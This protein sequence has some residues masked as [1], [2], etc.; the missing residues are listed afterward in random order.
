VRGETGDAVGDRQARLPTHGGPDPAR[1]GLDRAG[2][3]SGGVE[4]VFDAA[5]QTRRAICKGSA[6]VFPDELSGCLA[7]FRTVHA[8]SQQELR[9]RERQVRRTFRPGLV[10]RSLRWVR[11]VLN[12]IG[13]AFH[14]SVGVLAASLNRAGALGAALS[15]Q[16]G[17]LEQLGGTLVGM[18]GRAYEPLLERH[19]GRPVV[20][21]LKNPEG[22]TAPVTELPGYLVEYTQSHLAVFNVSQEPIET[23]ELQIDDG[24]AAHPVL[25][26]QTA[27]EEVVLRCQCDDP[28]V[29]RDLWSDS[30]KS[31]LSVVLLS[32]ATLSLRRAA[33]ETLTV[34]VERVRSIDVV[35]HRSAARVRFGSDG[36]VRR[37]AWRGRAPELDELPRVKPAD[38]A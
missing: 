6:L 12:T 3:T 34:A 26:I 35:C 2:R 23:F 19:I 17:S 38:H 15:A 37:P 32:G 29:V 36:E 9:A 20:L 8:L 33:G 10:R 4:L 18:A 7:I 1:H 28:I 13:D 24:D 22:T 30:S 31:D 11:S 5:Y 25:E 21:E 16:K 27:A 14:R